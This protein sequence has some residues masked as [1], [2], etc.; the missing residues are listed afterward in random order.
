MSQERYEDVVENIEHAKEYNEHDPHFEWDLAKA[1]QELENYEEALKY[2]E[3]AYTVFKEEY[4]FLEE[5]GYFLLEEG[6]RSKAKEIF[7]ALLAMDPTVD[8]IQDI[9]FQLEE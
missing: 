7:Q 1:H 9:L 3:S 8:E 6:Q 4:A 5:Y 2:Y